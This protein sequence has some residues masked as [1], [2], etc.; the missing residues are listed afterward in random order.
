[1]CHS[2]R[3]R[4]HV[5]ADV[6][7]SYTQT[8]FDPSQAQPSATNPLGN[9]AYPGYTSS[10]GPN[11]VDY[12]TVEYN[13]SRV[14]TYNLAYGGATVDADLVQP[15]QPTVL[16]LEDQVNKEFFP[17]YVSKTT[18]GWTSANSLF[19]FWIGINGA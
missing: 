3:S 7:R 6:L 1:M 13:Q 2:G 16:S 17:Y 4:Y 14:Q 10:N 9:P 11:W 12:L 18:A 8:G 15:Y 5:D 19:A